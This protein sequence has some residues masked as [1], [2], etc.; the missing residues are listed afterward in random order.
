MR[1]MKSMLIEP[2]VLII[3]YFLIIPTMMDNIV[4]EFAE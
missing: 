3:I 4:C 2:K 1:N